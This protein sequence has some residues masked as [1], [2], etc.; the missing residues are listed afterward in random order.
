MN[1]QHPSPLGLYILDGHTPVPASSVEQWAEWL[2]CTSEDKSRIVAQD[3]VQGVLVST[4]CIGI[5]SHPG[6]GEHVPILFETMVFNDQ[7]PQRR[8][9]TWEE[10][11]AGHK[12][13]LAAERKRQRL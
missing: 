1:E 7:Q 2:E 8:Y 9:C 6:E 12:E 4:I 11:E 5:D 10:A 3:H 13:M